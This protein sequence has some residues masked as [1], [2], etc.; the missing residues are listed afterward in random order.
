MTDYEKIVKKFGTPLYLFDI[1]ELQSRLEY[2]HKSLNKDLEI[3]YYELLS[4]IILD[5][6]NNNHFFTIICN[7]K[8]WFDC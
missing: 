7:W 8:T 5:F 2:L 6:D 1:D 3:L 4:K